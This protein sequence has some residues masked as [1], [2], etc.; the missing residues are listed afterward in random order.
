[1]PRSRERLVDLQCRRPF[2][3]FRVSNVQRHWR[4]I[5]HLKGADVVPDDWKQI[6]P[7]QV[8]ERSLEGFKHKEKAYYYCM[9]FMNARQKRCQSCLTS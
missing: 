3:D 8:I 9:T 4:N 5:S 6:S 1:M 7:D 2:F